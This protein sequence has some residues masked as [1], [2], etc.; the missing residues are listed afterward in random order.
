MN[1]PIHAALAALTLIGSLLAA[2]RQGPEVLVI[3]DAL[4]DVPVALRPAPGKPAY[5]LLMGN[6]ES[7][8]GFPLG[9]MPRPDPKAMEAELTKVLAGQGFIRTEVGGPMPRIALAL[10]WGTAGLASEDT[11]GTDP[12]TGQRQDVDADPAADN[13]PNSQPSSATPLHATADTWIPPVVAYNVK[14]FRQLLGLHKPNWQSV[15]LTDAD[16]LSEAFG[17]NRVYLMVMAFDLSALLRKQKVVLWRTRM[18]IDATDHNLPDSFALMLA[19]AAPY[20]GR[21]TATPMLIDD[22]VREANVKLGEMKIIEE[23][24]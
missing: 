20:F 12:L 9:G 14:E 6:V 2:G 13:A 24:P 8:I 18:S 21:N 7:D 1:R 10:S 3:G 15:S 4:Q 19:S 23:K 11:P 17:S 22:R 16:R 5:Y